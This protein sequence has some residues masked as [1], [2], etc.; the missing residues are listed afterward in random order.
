MKAFSVKPLLIE[1]KTGLVEYEKNTGLIC[2]FLIFKTLQMKKYVLL[3]LLLPAIQVISYAQKNDTLIIKPTDVNTRVLL[4]GTHRWLVYFKMGKDSSRSRYQVWSRK[5]DMLQ[6][7]GRDA[8]SVTQEWENN[9]TVIHTVYTVCDRKDFSTLYQISWSKGPGK[10]A[11]DFL[12]KEMKIDG[13]LVDASDTLTANKR[14]RLAFE[15]ALTQYTLDWHLDL[16]V[17]PILPYKNNT[18]FAINFYD[19][20]FPAPKLV[21]YTVTGSGTLTGYNGQPIDCWLL[22]HNDADRGKNHEVFYISKKTKEV[23]QLEQ[24]FSG[25]FRYK[26]KLPFSN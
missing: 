9:D 22:E 3:I 12:N 13:K 14:R 6:Y 4:P 25:R 8:I 10:V 19:P 24:E 11:F 23:V 26:V 16:E 1:N 15:Q 17:F 21:Y 20:G 2:R 18:T 5:I 7:K